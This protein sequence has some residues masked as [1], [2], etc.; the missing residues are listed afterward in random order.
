MCIIETKRDQ[1]LESLS[2]L[3]TYPEMPKSKKESDTKARIPTPS[4][5]IEED[6]GEDPEGTSK[7]EESQRS[8]SEEPQNYR[9]KEPRNRSSDIS[10]STN[11]A[12][13]ADEADSPSL[14]RPPAGDKKEKLGV[15]IGQDVADSYKEVWRQLLSLNSNLNKGAVVDAALRVAISD[16][17]ERGTD[18]SL[19]QLIEHLHEG[20]NS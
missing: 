4:L 16:F 15:H 20:G 2:C 5:N 9:T 10:G 14:I 8:G 18:S 7:K 19:Y 3:Q 13:S 12:T 6:D 1:L 11:S 17:Q